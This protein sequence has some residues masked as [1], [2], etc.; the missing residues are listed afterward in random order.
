[1]FWIKDLGC[2]K[3]GTVKMQLSIG[4]YHISAGFKAIATHN[5]IF[6]H[7]AEHRHTIMDVQSFVEHGVENKT[8]VLENL[9]I[10]LLL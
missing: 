7:L 2:V 5:S 3:D 1:V 8:L 10:R 6:N 9:N 4:H